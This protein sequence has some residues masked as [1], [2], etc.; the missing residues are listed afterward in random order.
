MS[1]TLVVSDIGVR[2]SGGKPILLMGQHCITEKNHNFLQDCDY[3]VSPPVRMAIDERLEDL[4]LVRE[5]EY[6]ILP[7]LSNA[8]NSVHNLNY[9]DRAWRIIVGHWLRRFIQVGLNRINAITTCYENYSVEELLVLD[10]RQIPLAPADSSDAVRKFSSAEWNEAFIGKIASD[11]KFGHVEYFTEPENEASPY[12]SYKS[13]KR[14]RT[15]NALLNFYNAFGKLFKNDKSPLFISTYLPIGTL[16]A[17]QIRMGEFPTLERAEEVSFPYVYN[18]IMREKIASV[19]SVSNCSSEFESYVRKVIS[20]FI[21]VSYIEN[22]KEYFWE[23]N[24]RSWPKKPNFIFTS[25]NFDTNDLFKIYTAS[26]VDLGS[27]YVVG[28]HGNNY[29]TNRFSTP[30]IEEETSSKFLTWG[31]TGDRKNYRPTFCLKEPSRTWE[32][33]KHANGVILLNALHFPWRHNTWDDVHE[34]N[35]YWEDQY[36]FVKNL[37]INVRRRLVVRLH[38]AQKDHEDDHLAKWRSIDSDISIEKEGQSFFKSLK[39][40]SLVVHTYDSTGLLET[41]AGNFPSI[42]FWQNNLSH[43]FPHMLGEYEGLVENSIVHLSPE[44]AARHLN[45]YVENVSNWWETDELQTFRENF[46]SRLCRKERF[47]SHQLSRI[48]RDE[49]R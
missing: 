11:Y 48:F 39:K 40:A 44:S 13:S 35:E 15:I 19:V 6:S 29:G 30:T 14:S 10:R 23:A 20:S 4:R 28:Q 2:A 24:R 42:A 33:F 21:P 31:W 32:S 41:V 9:S 27:S 25:N 5:V 22:F 12:L 43:V 1:R 36:S 17:T 47:P 16:L 45:K 26:K 34:F 8:L 49:L 18:Q 7:D 38:P 37:E 46:V 3:A